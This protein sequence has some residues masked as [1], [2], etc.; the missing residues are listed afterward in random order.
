MTDTDD[1]TETA[2]VSDHELDQLENAVATALRTRS[3]GDLNVLGFG[4][5]SVALGFPFDQPRC[6]CKRTPP[7]TYDQYQAYRDLVLGYTEELRRLG[8][9]AVDTDVR[10][11]NRGGKT[12]AYLVQPLMPAETLGHN[13][14]RASEP[15]PDNPFL[16]TLSETIGMAS[17]SISIDAQI[18]NW[19]W[20]GT[21]L[22]LIDVGSPFVW[23]DRGR[24]RFD[25]GP[26]LPM[27]P[28]PVRGQVRR[29]L[30]KMINRWQTP[31]GVAVDVLAN[32]M[33][34]GLDEWV[35]PGLEAL[36]R[37]VATEHPIDRLEVEQI[38]DEDRKTWPRLVRLKRVQ[39]AWQ[40]KIRRRP[41]DFFIQSTYAAA[42]PN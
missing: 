25:M 15:N 34:E 32:L 23:D 31:R 37:A 3:L 21:T 19:S 18:T 5:V 27:I 33:R 13:I 17:S 35:E 41:Y 1:R 36:N 16:V 4:E 9:D 8:V 29:D 2:F 42:Q 28:A 7:L 22:S 14:L 24:L 26:F 40:T 20:D 6:I 30:E 38:Y 39:R 10:A 11:V 12:L